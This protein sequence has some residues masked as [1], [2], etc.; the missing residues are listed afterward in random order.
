MN[1]TVLIVTYKSHNTINTCI[2]SINKNVKIVIVENSSD[3]KFKNFLENKYKNV[4]CYLTGKNLGFGRANNFGLSLINTN[5]VL[6][7]NPDTKLESDTLDIL[8]NVAKNLK[9]FALLAPKIINGFNFGFFE[10]IE[11]NE[12]KKKNIFQVDYIKGFAMFFNKKKFS[13]IK[14]F[15]PNIF[16]YYEEIDLCRRL[17][18]DNQKIYLVSNARVKHAGGKSHGDSLDL[19]ME[20][21]RNWHYLWSMFYYYKKHFGKFFAYKKTLRYFFLSIT[22]LIIYFFFSKNKYLVHKSRFLGLLNSYIGREAHYRPYSLNK[23]F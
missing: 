10:N 6:L 12:I 8:I 14:F 5:Y 18:K 13:K 9:D 23:L 4:K 19:E 22:K 7:L 11:K 15:D 2:D 17:K 20:L 3:K 16:I 21:S 1:C